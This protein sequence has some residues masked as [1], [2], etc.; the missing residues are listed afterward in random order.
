LA[1]EEGGAMK[2]VS[3]SLCFSL[4]WQLPWVVSSSDMISGS[5]VIK[6]VIVSMFKRIEVIKRNKY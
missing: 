2:E 6:S 1:V 4:V 5:Q 3:P